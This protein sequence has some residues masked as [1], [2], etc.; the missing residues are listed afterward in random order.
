ME[1]TRVQLHNWPPNPSDP[2][3]WVAPFGDPIHWWVVKRVYG[4]YVAPRVEFDARDEQGRPLAQRP[5][6]HA[7]HVDLDGSHHGL[8]DHDS[9]VLHQV[10]PSQSW[11]VKPADD[12][13][14]ARIEK[15]RV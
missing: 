10:A 2:G 1:P 14:L 11:Y 8:P 9:V 7:Y 6:L 5:E 13:Y 4:R 15:Y 3:G 12:E